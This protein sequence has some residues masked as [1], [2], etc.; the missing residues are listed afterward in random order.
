MKHL[1]IGLSCI[2][3]LLMSVQAAQ[4]WVFPAT[5][6]AEWEQLLQTT[7]QQV[8]FIRTMDDWNEFASHASE[9]ISPLHALT[10]EQLAAFTDSLVIR[11]G[12][13][14]TAEIGILKD[15]L[16]LQNY[17]AALR[18]FGIAVS[19]AEDHKDYKCEGFH[20]CVALDRYI[21]MTGC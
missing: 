18:A 2:V 8:T 17:A 10:A 20:N 4:A 9:Q 6:D 15:N 19:L 1:F 16:T 3:L 21:C 5:T 13:L 12:G 7:P 11:D 14:V